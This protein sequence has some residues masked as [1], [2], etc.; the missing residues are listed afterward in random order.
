MRDRKMIVIVEAKT[1][2]MDRDEFYYETAHCP[3]AGGVLASTVQDPYEM[4]T[5]TREH[6]QGKIFCNSKGDR[7]CLGL[8]NEV[9]KALAFPFELIEQ[10]ANDI[11][12]LRSENSKL[13]QR[14]RF[15]ES[16][17]RQRD[18]WHRLKYLFTGSF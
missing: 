9:S 7:I 18:I 4:V 1:V 5:I 10:N 16:A 3:N 8:S 12:N 11:D 14:L 13:I 15:S 2:M 6:I 17:W